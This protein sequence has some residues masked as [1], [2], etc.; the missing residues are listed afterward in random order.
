MPDAEDKATELVNEDVE[1][2]WDITVEYDTVVEASKEAAPTPFSS[3]C[4]QPPEV[5]DGVA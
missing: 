3:D 2:E 1:A 5:E 4:F